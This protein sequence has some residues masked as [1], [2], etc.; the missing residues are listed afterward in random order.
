M[1][2]QLITAV[3]VQRRRRDGG[4]AAPG[5]GFQR[6]A[7]LAVSGADSG[8]RLAGAGDDEEPVKAFIAVTAMAVRVSHICAARSRLLL[9]QWRSLAVRPNQCT[10]RRR[11]ASHLLLG[12]HAR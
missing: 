5:G 9:L 2:G 8:P 12:R 6:A 10:R 11:R 3:P 1:R 4:Q 7:G